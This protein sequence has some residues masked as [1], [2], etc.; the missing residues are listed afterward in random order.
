[1][2]MSSYP[3]CNVKCNVDDDGLLCDMFG[4]G[5][6]IR[7]TNKQNSIIIG[8]CVI[9]F[10][11]VYDNYMNSFVIRVYLVLCIYVPEVIECRLIDKN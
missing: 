7:Q 11:V 8:L 9:V 4:A 1:M 10:F 2:M 5:S 6:S 3:L